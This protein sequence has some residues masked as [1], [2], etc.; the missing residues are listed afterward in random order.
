MI[1]RLLGLAVL[2]CLWVLAVLF[3]PQTAESQTCPNFVIE[4]FGKSTTGGCG[5]KVINVTNLNDSGSGSLR[6]CLEASGTRICNPTV[7]GW[8][9]LTNK[10]E[11]SDGNLTLDGS[12][13]P[14]GGFGVKGQSVLIRASNVIFRHVRFRTGACSPDDSCEYDALSIDG[15]PGGIQNIVLDHVTTGW[16]DDGTLDIVGRVRN[17][18]VQW[19]IIHDSLGENGCSIVGSP[20]DAS[21]ITMHHNLFYQCKLRAPEQQNGQ[22]DYRNN[23][24]YRNSGFPSTFRDVQFLDPWDVAP[25][26]VTN[27]VANY[28]RAGSKEGIGSRVAPISLVNN[29]SQTANA[30]VYM[31]GNKTDTTAGIT[32]TQFEVDGS[33]PT[34]KTSPFAYP[35]VITTSAAQAYTDVL[36]NAGATLPCRDSVDKGV[37]SNIQNRGGPVL[38][39]GAPLTW[40]DLS[41]S[42]GN[43]QQLAAPSNLQ[44]SPQ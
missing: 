14:N 1:Q 2:S 13:V 3:M 9:T 24:I 8:V 17:V 4:G 36:A 37:V 35:S 7:S 20:S 22:L 42:C 30:G 10:I 6:A 28:Y 21:Q 41:A 15:P 43:T 31:E 26:T 40:P 32:D 44:V 23:V 38:V 25:A 18:T 16:A 12:T 5:G 11:I 29:G 33:W 34:P 19:S 27:L 39:R